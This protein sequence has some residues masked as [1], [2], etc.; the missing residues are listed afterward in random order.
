MGPTFAKIHDGNVIPIDSKSDVLN[1]ALS[2]RLHHH[3]TSRHTTR[4]ARARR[5]VIK[6]RHEVINIPNKKGM[7]NPVRGREQITYVKLDPLPCLHLGLISAVFLITSDLGYPSPHCGRTLRK[8]PCVTQGLPLHPRKST[9]FRRHP[10][11]Q[12]STP[13]RRFTR[14]AW[15]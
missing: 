14:R 3:F 6:W 4:A 12:R 1:D 9:T 15:H 7:V 11:T 2:S 8:P 13:C 5:D 10:T